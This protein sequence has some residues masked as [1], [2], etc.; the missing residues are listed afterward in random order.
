MTEPEPDYIKIWQDK[1]NKRNQRRLVWQCV[2]WGIAILAATHFP[3]HVLIW[4]WTFQW[5]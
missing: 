5:I 2:W 3:G 4:L 1:I